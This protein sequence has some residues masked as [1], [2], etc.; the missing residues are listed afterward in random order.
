MTNMQKTTTATCNSIRVNDMLTKLSN[1]Q[2][3]FFSLK[4]GVLGAAIGFSFMVWAYLSRVPDHLQSVFLRSQYEPS[5]LDGLSAVLIYGSTAISGFLI[6]FIFIYWLYEKPESSGVS[7]T[8]WV[9]ASLGYG[10][11]N[12]FIGGGI[13]MP[14]ADEILKAIDASPSVGTLILVIADHL[15]RVPLTVWLYGT[16]VLYSSLISAFLFALGGLVIYKM[17]ETDR[18]DGTRTSYATISTIL[19]SSLVVLLSLLLP[20]SILQYLG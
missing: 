13:F 5:R 18:F 17:H 14:L 15:F 20:V 4:I 9:M 8:S 2:K 3:V 1:P 6:A 10:V 19:V 7:K 12:A 16:Q 11:S